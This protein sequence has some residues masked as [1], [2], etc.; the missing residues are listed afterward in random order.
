MDYAADVQTDLPGSLLPPLALSILAHVLLA[1]LF[2]ARSLHAPEPASAPFQVE[3]MQPQGRSHTAKSQSPRLNRLRRPE[4]KVAPPKT[5]IVSPPD[6]PERPLI[7]RG[8]S[9][10]ATAAPSKR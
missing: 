10:I 8:F 5:Q 1:L 3:L 9:A 6:S 4:P 7:R 2:V